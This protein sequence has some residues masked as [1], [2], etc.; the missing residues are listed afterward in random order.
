MGQHVN[1]GNG[2]NSLKKTLSKVTKI[3]AFFLACWAAAMLLVF[4]F[5]LAVIAAWAI[6]A[7]CSAVFS[8]VMQVKPVLHAG[9]VALALTAL[10]LVFM[11]IKRMV[12]VKRREEYDE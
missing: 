11:L 8:A 7:N 10:K 12:S 6:K 2:K 5:N 9:G 4:L 1:H 3:M